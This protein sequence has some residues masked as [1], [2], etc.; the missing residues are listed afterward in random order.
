MKV[1]CEFCEAIAN[2]TQAELMDMGWSRVIIY[3]PVRK[4]ITACPI[5]QEEAAGKMTEILPGRFKIETKKCLRR[6][7]SGEN[8]RGST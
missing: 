7:N 4:T 5:H 2:G 1:K 8:K 6:G 3:A